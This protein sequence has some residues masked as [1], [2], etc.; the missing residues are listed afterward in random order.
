MDLQQLRCFVAAVELRSIS[1]AAK[2]LDVSQPAV[3]RSLQN[4]EHGLDTTLLDRTSR[5]VTP[6][7]AGQIFY[8]HARGILSQVER[9]VSALTR[10]KG[11][12]PMTVVV[13]TTPSFVD[14]LLPEVLGRFMQA[15]PQARIVIRKALLPELRVLLEHGEIDIAFAINLDGQ[16]VK[17][18][19]TEEL[20]RAKTVFVVGRT[21]PLFGAAEVSAAELKKH[22]W[23]LLDSQDVRNFF[24]ALFDGFGLTPPEPVVRANSM[25]LLKAMAQEG[26]VIIFLPHFMVSQELAAGE[27]AALPFGDKQGALSACLL[28]SNSR[29]RPEVAA[30]A[31]I[32]RVA[33]GEFAAQGNPIRLQDDSGRAA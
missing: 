9:S 14:H 1:D 12:G 31:D 5:G 25:R 33:A 15:W 4:L 29:S 28:L 20:L 2:A 16:M 3:T 18:L 8:E 13:G 10:L 7:G 26:D 6:T 11:E 27:L 30:L 19:V 21:H 32:A 24:E 17:G 23:A 22:K